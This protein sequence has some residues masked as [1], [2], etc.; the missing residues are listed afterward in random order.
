MTEEGW[1][2]LLRHWPGGAYEVM[3]GMAALVFHPP[4]G[5]WTASSAGDTCPRAASSG[6]RLLAISDLQTAEEVRRGFF[7]GLRCTMNDY[8]EGEGRTGN[9]N[10]PKNQAVII[11]D[12]LLIRL[13]G[14]RLQI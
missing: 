10:A 6:T 2:D 9:G 8:Q 7:Y 14:D 5:A 12:W 11:T 13:I 1:S 4:T 3:R